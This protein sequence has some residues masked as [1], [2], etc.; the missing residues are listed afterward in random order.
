MVGD[1][2]DVQRNECKVTAG[3]DPG[4]LGGG[5]LWEGRRTDQLR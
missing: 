1:G 3:R 2:E 4:G 5:L